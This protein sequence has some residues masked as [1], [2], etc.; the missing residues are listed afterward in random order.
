MICPE[1][2]QEMQCFAGRYVDHFRANGAWFFREWVPNCFEC[3][4]CDV[5]ELDYSRKRVAEDAS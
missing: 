2:N 1:C 5:R 4:S 3:E